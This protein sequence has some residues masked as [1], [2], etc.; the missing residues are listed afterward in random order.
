M[1]DSQG[2]QDSD[3]YL[4]ALL[5]SGERACDEDWS[6]ADL[7]AMLSHQL[8]TPLASDV[9]SGVRSMNCAGAA[10]RCTTFGDLLRCPHPTSNLLR[11]VKG[12]AKRSLRSG[13][14]IAEP[15]ETLPK[16][17]ARFLYVASVLQARKHGIKGVSNLSPAILSREVSRCLTM[18]WLP[19][20]ARQLLR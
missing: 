5:Q 15:E 14:A 6:A 19:E 9:P 17:I 4:V 12:L 16:E 20:E 2:K 18:A 10:C 1:Q 7:A 8:E 13:G 11:H 3:A